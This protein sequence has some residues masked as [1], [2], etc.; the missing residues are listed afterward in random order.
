M[1][2]P[3]PVSEPA[4][5]RRG[6]HDRDRAGRRA[7]HAHEVG[8]PKVLHPLCGRPMLAF[9][10]DAWDETADGRGGR[11]RAVVVYSPA[12]AAVH[13]AFADRADFALQDEPRGTGDAVRAG[14]AAVA[15]DAAEVLVLSGD[16]P[17]ITAADLPP[18]W[19]RAARTMPRSRWRRCSRPT[20]PPGPGGPQRVRHRRAHRGGQGRHGGRT[21]GQRGQRRAVRLRCRLAAPAD[22]FPGAIA[23][24][25]RAVPD[26]A[27]PPRPRGRPAR[28][29]GRVRRRRA[30]R[31]HQRPFAPGG[32]RVEP[33]GA[34]QRVAHARRA[35]RCAT[36]P[37][38]ISTGT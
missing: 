34:A 33:A 26:R 32:R 6:A 13:D 17:L 36:H 15:E 25:R 22:R 29:R 11:R 16:V 23:R 7:G 1:N 18:C 19:T 3:D 35:S 12:V 14:L 10:L 31:R 27:H 24:D 30:I 38:S 9:V 28:E 20:R 8:L 37:R 4:H 21:R 2:P 5:A